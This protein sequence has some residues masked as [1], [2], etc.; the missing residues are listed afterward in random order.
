MTALINAA[1]LGKAIWIWLRDVGPGA[2]IHEKDRP[3]YGGDKGDFISA[4]KLPKTATQ[5]KF[6]IE[7]LPDLYEYLYELGS[8]SA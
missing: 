6:D 1:Q 3:C 5:F 7:I 4:D 8:V 2:R